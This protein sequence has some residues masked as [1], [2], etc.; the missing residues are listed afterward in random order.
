MLGL[1][2]AE[3]CTYKV[4]IFYFIAITYYENAAPVY[5]FEGLTITSVETDYLESATVKLITEVNLKL[6]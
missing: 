3:G 1:H 2:W 5:I 6:Y 4:V